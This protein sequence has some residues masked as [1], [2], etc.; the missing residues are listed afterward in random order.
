MTLLL[1]ELEKANLFELAERE[2]LRE[3]KDPAKNLALGLD[4]AFE[5]LHKLDVTRRNTKNISSR[6]SK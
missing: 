1:K 3:G 5:L 6:Y 4:K 2:L